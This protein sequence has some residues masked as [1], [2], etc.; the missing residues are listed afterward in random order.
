MGGVVYDGD[1]TKSTRYRC[2]DDSSRRPRAR[3]VAG[4]ARIPQCPER[5]YC[6]FRWPGIGIPGAGPPPGAGLPGAGVPGAGVPGAGFPGAPQ[7]RKRGSYTN[8]QAQ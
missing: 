7:R 3:R 4:R 8:C 2:G 1:K 5:G 6:P